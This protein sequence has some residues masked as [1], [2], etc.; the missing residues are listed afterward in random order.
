MAVQEAGREKARQRVMGDRG[1]G[2]TGPTPPNSGRPG[3]H[4]TRDPR[5]PLRM[6]WRLG[7]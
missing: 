6:A 1:E 4:E 3:A 2:E 7:G 5:L